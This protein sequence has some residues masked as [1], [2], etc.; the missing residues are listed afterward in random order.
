MRRVRRV[1]GADR[2]G[3]NAL[4]EQ[5]VNDALLFGG[6]AVGVNAELHVHVL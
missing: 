3:V 5:V 2:Q 4:G 1:N 6:A